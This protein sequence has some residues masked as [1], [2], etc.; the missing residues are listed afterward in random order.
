MTLSSSGPLFS[1]R[2]EAGRRLA[3]ALSYLRGPDIVVLGLP[4]GGVPVAA[5]VARELGAPLDVVVVRRVIV[6]GCP[7]LVAGA[8]SE[9]DLTVVDI[10][11]IKARMV[12]WQGLHRAQRIARTAVERSAAVL[13]SDRWPEPLVGRTALIVDDGMA[14]GA[15]ARVACMSARAAERTRSSWLSRWRVPTPRRW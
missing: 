13:R 10:D 7:D 14:T 4:R 15:T 9:D 6:P 2:P 12:S 1:S 8:V 11:R 3:T 5:E